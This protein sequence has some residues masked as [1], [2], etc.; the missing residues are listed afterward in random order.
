MAINLGGRSF[1]VPTMPD[2]VVENFTG[3]L[4]GVREYLMGVVSDLP[5]WLPMAAVAALI[6]GPFGL[7]VAYVVLFASN[8]S[9]VLGGMSGGSTTPISSMLS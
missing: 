9:S 3:S 4:D 1:N 2:D 7:I 5:G 6:L 8:A